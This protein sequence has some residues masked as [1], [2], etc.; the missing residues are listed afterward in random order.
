MDLEIDQDLDFQRRTWTAERVRWIVMALLLVAGF[1]GL[2]GKG[3]LSE[4]MVIDPDGALWLS[5]E[6]FGRQETGTDLHIHI[7]PEAF[8]KGEARVWLNRAY[9]ENFKV[10]QVT[11]PPLRVEAGADR[12]TYVFVPVEPDRAARITVRLQ[13]LSMGSCEGEAGVPGRKPVSFRQCFYP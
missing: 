13:P 12:L 9:L 6:H 8:D 2:F 7:S 11:P 1:L 10:E 4:A 5:Y 3:P